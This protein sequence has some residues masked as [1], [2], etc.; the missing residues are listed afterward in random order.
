MTKRLSL[1]VPEQPYALGTVRRMARLVRD[2][3]LARLWL[4]QSFGIESHLAMAPLAA[5]DLAVPVGIGTALA[6][7][8]SPYDAALQARSLAAVLGQTV[9]VGYGA[10]DPQFVTAVLGGPLRR[11]ATYTA[12][13]ARLVRS[14]LTG[15]E[16]VGQT[17][18]LRMHAQLP[19]FDHPEV[20]V[21]TGVLRERMAEKSRD[22]A[23][24]V[25]TWLTP[26]RYVRDV[27]LPR[28]RRADGTRPRVVT[29]VPCALRRPGRNANLMVQLG[30]GQHVTRR[31]Y[32]EM[33]RKA[34][35]DLH[36][37]DPISGARELVR[38]GVFVYG[39]ADEVVAE[40]LSHFDHGVDEVVMNPTPVALTYGTDEAIT[41]VTD[42]VR[43]L[44]GYAYTDAA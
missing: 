26:R 4:G 27:L 38:A 44:R 33:L 15:E 35:L 23:E 2:H 1:L 16:T 40:L 12:E 22:V 6:A 32:A 41:D 14:L 20:E 5:E 7:L 9:S 17:E 21:G 10:A 37:S 28:L 36:E 29:N 11:P 25:V 43:E 8:R 30:C 31:H 13:Y 3:D 18:E 24:F 39:S 42:I 19:A 34:G